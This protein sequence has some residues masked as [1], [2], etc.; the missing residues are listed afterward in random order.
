MYEKIPGPRG[1][2]PGI[3][4]A[5]GPSLGPLP[6]IAILGIIG[7]PVGKIGDIVEGL[8]IEGGGGRITPGTLMLLDPP[9]DDMPKF[10]NFL[11]EK[12]Q[13]HK[14]ELETVKKK[15]IKKNIKPVGEIIAGIGDGM[16]IIPVG[17]GMFG[18]GI[19]DI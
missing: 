17:F 6:D 16:A 14:Y 7:G 15:P 10:S 19:L 1:I 18:G 13:Q 12:Q 8:P 11:V 9:V 4:I 2:I 3:A 5:P